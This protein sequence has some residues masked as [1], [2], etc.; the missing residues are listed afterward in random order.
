M[1]RLR[2]GAGRF[3][4]S[5]NCCLN[6]RLKRS[7]PDVARTRLLCL[8]LRTDDIIRG[9]GGREMRWPPLEPDWTP[10]VPLQL[11]DRSLQVSLKDARRETRR[12]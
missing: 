11:I 10:Q 4:A 1:S 7:V 5:T 9:R 3:A 8:H 6:E 2:K 12:L